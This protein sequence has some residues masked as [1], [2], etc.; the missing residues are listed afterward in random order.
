M[1]DEATRF[2]MRVSAYDLYG[3]PHLLLTSSA[4]SRPPTCNNNVQQK[5]NCTSC[6]H[7]PLHAQ[8]RARTMLRCMRTGQKKVLRFHQTHL[9]AFQHT[10][11]LPAQRPVHCTKSCATMLMR[12]RVAMFWMSSTGTRPMALHRRACAPGPRLRREA[13][14]KQPARASARSR[15]SPSLPRM[16]GVRG[17]P[18]CAAKSNTGPLRARSEDTTRAHLGMATTWSFPGG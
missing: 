9:Q 3:I 7:T 17:A 8:T 11:T 18:F 5:Y 10:K 12:A 6:T 4:I 13:V 15:T 2:P 14:W 1:P 16:R